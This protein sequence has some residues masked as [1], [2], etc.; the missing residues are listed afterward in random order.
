MAEQNSIVPL[1]LQA[2]GP[3]MT[4]PPC[5]CCWAWPWALSAVSLHALTIS[6]SS[7]GGISPHSVFRVRAP[8]TFSLF[9]R[10]NLRLFLL[11]NATL[12]SRS[13]EER[14]RVVCS[15]VHSKVC[16]YMPLKTAHLP[17]QP[18]L[19]NEMRDTEA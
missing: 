6:W 7:A 1:A 13:G 17:Q 16:F 8:G 19:D 18:L 15:L 11:L 9:R 14:E 3:K 4:L 2:M 5:L 10:Q 12:F